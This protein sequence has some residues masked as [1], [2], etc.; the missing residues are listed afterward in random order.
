M[1]VAFG[2]LYGCLWLIQFGFVVVFG[3][4]RFTV[5]LGFVGCG[6]SSWNCVNSVGHCVYCGFVCIVDI[7]L[8]DLFLLWVVVFL[9]FVMIACFLCLCLWL[10]VVSFVL[11]FVVLVWC[12]RYYGGVCLVG[13]DWLGV[14]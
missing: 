3:L 6:F 12:I 5:G 9:Y 4:R 10:I 8:F 11:G 7:I 14:S 13:A 2:W 1:A